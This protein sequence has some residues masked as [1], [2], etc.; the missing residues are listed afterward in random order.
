MYSSK[1]HGWV[2]SY[3]MSINNPIYRH[4]HTAWR[5]F[6]TL[7][8]LVDKDTGKWSGGRF[9]LA[10]ITTL[11]PTTTYQALKRL[12]KA[13]MLTLSS[14]NKYTVI[15]ICNWS[16]FQRINDTSNDNRMTTN[17]QQNDTLTRIKNKEIRNSTTYYGKPEINEMFDYW[18]TNTGIEISARIKPN[19]NA[20]NNLLKKHGADT[21]KRLVDGVVIAQNE[22]YAPAISDFVDLQQK[23]NAL[24]VWGKKH[25]NKTNLGVKL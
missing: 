20:C 16:S 11:K 17:G 1:I 5:V 10:E 8:W 22:K 24:L 23:L 25:T 7:L 12:K 21:L 6:S 19:R 4:D 14:N 9:Q 2:R 3:R 15:Y 18:S 13:K